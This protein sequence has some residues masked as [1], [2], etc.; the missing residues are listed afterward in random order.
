MESE[1]VTIS[2]IGGFLILALM[3]AMTYIGY[4]ANKPFPWENREEEE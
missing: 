2:W 3:T 1:V 4:Y